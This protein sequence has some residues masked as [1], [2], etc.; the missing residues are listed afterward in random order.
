MPELNPSAQRCLTR[1]FPGDF[2]SWIVHLVYICVKNQQIHKSFIHFI[3]Y[4]W[5]FL[6]VSA[7]HCH[8]QGAFLVPSERCSIEEQSIEYCG[9]ACCV[10]TTRPSTIFYR[11]TAF[12]NKLNFCKTYFSTCTVHLGTRWRSGWGTAATNRKVAGSIPDDVI[13]VF[14][15]HNTAGRTMALGSTQPLPEMSTRNISWG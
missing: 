2:A 13:G 10:D 15:W 4:V 8:P 11:Q 1:F 5:Y 3:N 7:L 9:W 12:H 14:H 6:H